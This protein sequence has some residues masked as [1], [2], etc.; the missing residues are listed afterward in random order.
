MSE[1]GLLCWTP[2]IT[3][4]ND[5]CHLNYNETH[6]GTIE[7]FVN[8]TWV[9]FSISSLTL[10]F[11]LWSIHSSQATRM[12]SLPTWMTLTCQGIWQKSSD[13]SSKRIKSWQLIRHMLTHRSSPKHPTAESKSSSTIRTI[14]IH[15]LARLTTRPTPTYSLR[16]ATC[17]MPSCLLIT[18]SQAF[19]SS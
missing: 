13:S 4:Y 9:S 7:K 18:F 10:L 11:R 14:T 3:Y 17:L 19:G 15:T 8:A 16:I 5:T 6:G 12:K 1:A 2:N